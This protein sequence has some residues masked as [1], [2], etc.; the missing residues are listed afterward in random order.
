MVHLCDELRPVA[1]SVAEELA[2]RVALRIVLFEGLSSPANILIR[3]RHGRCPAVHDGVVD[4][5][6]PGSTRAK[7]PGIMYL[8]VGSVFGHD[9]AVK[10]GKMTREEANAKY[11]ELKKGMAR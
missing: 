4:R 2:L 5:N 1:L 9:G 6:F 10:S 8:P 11:A 7:W 3:S